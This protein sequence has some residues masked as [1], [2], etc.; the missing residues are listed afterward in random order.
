MLAHP[1]YATPPTTTNRQPA[2]IRFRVHSGHAQ[3]R[4]GRSPTHPGLEGGVTWSQLTTNRGQ[5]LR[6]MLDSQRHPKLWTESL[7][8]DKTGNVALPQ[9]AVDDLQVFV[10]LASGVRQT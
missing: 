4:G 5:S 7:R 10:V 9:G 2:D 3:E 1:A 8:D 6:E